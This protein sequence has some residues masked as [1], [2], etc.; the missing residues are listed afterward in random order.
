MKN[1]CFAKVWGGGCWGEQALGSVEV[2]EWGNHIKGRFVTIHVLEQ[3]GYSGW[4][5]QSIR[6]PGKGEL[7]GCVFE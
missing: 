5:T 2:V 6:C 1:W 4:C 3:E 7:L